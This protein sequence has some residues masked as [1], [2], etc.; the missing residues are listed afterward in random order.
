MKKILL[1]TVYNLISSAIVLCIATLIFVPFWVSVFIYATLNLSNLLTLILYEYVTIKNIKTLFKRLCFWLRYKRVKEYTYK[2]KD[3][4][5]IE[6]CPLKLYS[7]VYAT[8]I[9]STACQLCGN[10]EF[11][12]FEKK[13]IRCKHIKN[14]RSF[15]L[16]N[17]LKKLFGILVIA[18]LFASCSVYVNCNFNKVPKYKTTQ[19]DSTVLQINEY[20]F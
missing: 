14:N 20:W 8:K 15:N 7:G 4:L 17:W 11:F 9:G 3:G 19:Q 13:L 18:L 10:N 1:T 5:C 16:L 12:N 2:T 6:E